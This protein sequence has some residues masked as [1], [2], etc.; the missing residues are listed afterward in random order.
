[1]AIKWNEKNATRPDYSAGYA[2]PTLVPNPTY[3]G[4][5]LGTEW[6][7]SVRIMSDVWASVRYAVVWTGTAVEHVAVSNSEFGAYADAVEVDATPE[8]RAA[9]IAWYAARERERLARANEA[10]VDRVVLAAF[11]KVPGREVE[12]VAGRKIPRGTTGRLFWAGE[13][14]FGRRLGVE[15]A[16]GERVFTSPGNVE[17]SNP[18]EFV[19]VD[20]LMALRARDFSVEAAT[21]AAARVAAL[22]A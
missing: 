5:V 22:A 14:R 7:H 18:D 6:D 16:S 17:V 4:A 20:E 12:V 1:M 15:L 13:T 8:V 11:A 21:L 2:N 3:D 10:A 9:A 19:D